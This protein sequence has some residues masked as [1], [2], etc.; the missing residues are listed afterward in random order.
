MLRGRTFAHGAGEFPRWHAMRDSRGISR[1]GPAVARCS[2]SV[3]GWRRACGGIRSTKGQPMTNSSD[4]PIAYLLHCPKCNSEMRLIGTEWETEVR[5]LYTF[6]CT[7]CG[8]VEVRVV[9][10]Q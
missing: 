8:Q 4:E 6:E 3:A 9:I 7:K 1:V 10:V 2:P 5:D